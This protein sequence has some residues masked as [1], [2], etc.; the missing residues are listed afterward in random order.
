MASRCW[1]GSLAAL[2][3]LVGLAASAQA[4][5]PLYHQVRK[6][7]LTGS[8]GW[9]YINVDADTERLYISRST[10][11]Q[12]VDL[13][14]GKLAGTIPNTTGVHG[15][16]IDDEDGLGF[17]SDGRANTVTEFNLSTLATIA[18]I[19]VGDGPDCIIYD[20]ATDRV[21]TF[22]GRGQTSTAIDA[23]SGKVVGT[24]ALPGRPE[25][26]VSDYNGMLYDN[27]EDKSE[28][29]AIDP[30][31]LQIKFVWS[32]APGDSPSGLTMDRKSRRLFSVCDNQKMIVMDADTG[33]V[34]ATPTIGNGPDA[35]VFDPK[36]SLVFSPNGE[37]GT[38]TEIQENGDQY[39]IVGTIPTQ[40]TARTLTYDT[41]TRHLFTVGATPQPA[42]P[43]SDQPRWHRS[44]QPGSF[45]VLE[46]AP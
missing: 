14:S 38:L 20:P 15:I 13:K 45:V 10:Y 17:I 31:T 9:D 1:I 37:D 39:T 21:F 3:G 43:G 4:A 23:K 34:I 5:A 12:V 22:N 11:V 35:C 18:T 44:Y 46:Y 19:P 40:M 28:I 8:E 30:K 16:A 25:Y 6:I 7:Y 33:N 26:A 27:I 32:L 29:A 36:A 2:V 42:P 41:K 24:I